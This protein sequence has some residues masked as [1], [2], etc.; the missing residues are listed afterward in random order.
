MA[1]LLLSV[2]SCASEN[3]VQNVGSENLVQNAGF[4]TIDGQQAAGGDQPG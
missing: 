1:A 4:E 3:L 2:V